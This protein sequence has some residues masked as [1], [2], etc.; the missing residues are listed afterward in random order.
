[1]KGPK[2]IICKKKF[3][4]ENLH[5]SGL[6]SEISYYAQHSCD[7]DSNGHEYNF[8]ISGPVR[9]TKE[10]ALQAVNKKFILKEGN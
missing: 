6:V 3:V 8:Y 5:D 4:V 10:K 1:M 7:A 2:C 9:K